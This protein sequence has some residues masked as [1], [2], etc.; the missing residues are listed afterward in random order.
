MCR[1]AGRLASGHDSAVESIRRKKAKLCLLAN[2]S[3]ERLREEINREIA[4]SKSNIKSIVIDMDMLE[5]KGCTG[6]KSAVLAVND[7]NFAKPM[8]E[9]LGEPEGNV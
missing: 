3:S 1:K 8:L 7:E 4:L 6:L 5:I 9:I 2:D